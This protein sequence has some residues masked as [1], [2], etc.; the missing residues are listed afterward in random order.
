MKKQFISNI[1]IWDAL[2]ESVM[3]L[4]QSKFWIGLMGCANFA[5][6]AVRKPIG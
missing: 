3:E 6:L 1:V 4:I 5:R 2:P